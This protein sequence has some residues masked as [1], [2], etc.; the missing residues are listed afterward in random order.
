[1]APNE[2]KGHLII[3]GK[4]I[5]KVYSRTKT[6][7]SSHAF[8]CDLVLTCFFYGNLYNNTLIIIMRIK[9]PPRAPLLYPVLFLVVIPFGPVILA[10][11]DLKL[12]IV[13]SGF[14]S[15]FSIAYGLYPLFFKMEKYSKK[16]GI[17]NIIFELFFI[18]RLFIIGSLFV[19]F[20]FSFSFI[21]PIFTSE[22]PLRAL[23]S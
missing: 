20:W 15:Y 9:S 4:F 11:F 19:A 3:L 1:M 8:D 18:K 7:D 5:R 10:I 17:G 22:H 23:V 2:Q 16:R 14:T 21:V 6:E 13:V 12:F